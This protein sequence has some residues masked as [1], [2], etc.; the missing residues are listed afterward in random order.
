MKVIRGKTREVGVSLTRKEAH[1]HFKRTLAG[2][3]WS[4]IRGFHV[5]RHSLRVQSRRGRR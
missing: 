5:F 3:K 4:K 2:S 1:D